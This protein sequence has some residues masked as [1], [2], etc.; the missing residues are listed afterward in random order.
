MLDPVRFL[1]GYFFVVLY[2]NMLNLFLFVFHTY[3][4]AREFSVR[5]VDKNPLGYLRW[6][7]L[8]KGHKDL[9]GLISLNYRA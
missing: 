8:G 4:I 1:S 5:E 6:N 9:A 2:R 7:M 3:F